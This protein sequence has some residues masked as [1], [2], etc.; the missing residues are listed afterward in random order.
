MFVLIIFGEYFHLLLEGNSQLLRTLQKSLEVFPGDF[1][2]VKQ[3]CE[4]RK[5]CV[6]RMTFDGP[7]TNTF[8]LEIFSLN[9]P[10]GPNQS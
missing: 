10:T 3:K 9:G 7:K 8:E 6:A 2:N 5:S 4:F 1:T